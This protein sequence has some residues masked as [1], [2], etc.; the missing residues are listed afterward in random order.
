MKPAEYWL[1]RQLFEKATLDSGN[2]ILAALPRAA[3]RACTCGHELLWEER[4]SDEWADESEE[5]ESGALRKAEELLGRVLRISIQ[6]F[7]T[8]RPVSASPI[9]DRRLWL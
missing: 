8:A 5:P 6:Y 3:L 2:V 7:N 9:A 1:W 4:R